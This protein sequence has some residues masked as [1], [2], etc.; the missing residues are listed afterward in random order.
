[1]MRYD[2]SILQFPPDSGKWPIVSPSKQK[3]Y[4]LTAV[5]QNSRHYFGEDL[6]SKQSVD[7][8]HWGI[9]YAKDIIKGRWP[10]LEVNLVKDRYASLS[11]VNEI[12]QGPWPEAEQNISK[13]A[14]TSVRYVKVTKQRFLAAEPKIAIY[15][16][17]SYE[18][19]VLLNMRFTEGEKVISN[20][21]HASVYLIHL[22]KLGIDL[23]PLLKAYPGFIKAMKTISDKIIT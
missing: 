21:A 22:A 4:Y 23:E 17:H 16:L 3:E 20:S 11:Y 2:S 9:K 19:A 5:R 8:F 15:G 6:L 18:Y 10:E 12:V 1:M 14:H 7:G 13:C